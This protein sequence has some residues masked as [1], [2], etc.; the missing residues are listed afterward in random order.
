M[1][2]DIVKISD[3]G[4]LATFFIRSDGAL[5]GEMNA[6]TII[7]AS[8]LSDSLGETNAE[9]LRIKHVSC[10]NAGVD[11]TTSVG[12]ANS[13]IFL[14]FEGSVDQMALIL[15]KGHTSLSPGLTCD[16]VDDGSIGTITG[17]IALST[18]INGDE[19]IAFT[20]TITVEK[21]RGYRGVR[22]KA[23]MLGAIVG[24]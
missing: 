5:S 15:P 6:V 2:Y 20:M 3:A 19:L 4:R 1:A 23:G 12:G 10:Q 13:C 8:T 7:D 24:E 18:G 14:A 17:D 11:G 21:Y 9:R 16:H 22:S